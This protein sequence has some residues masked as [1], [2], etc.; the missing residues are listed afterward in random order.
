MVAFVAFVVVEQHI[1]EPSIVTST[2]FVVFIE[3]TIKQPISTTRTITKVFATVEPAVVK[4]KLVVQVV[5]QQV[6]LAKLVTIAYFSFV[7][8]EHTSIV[9]F[10]ESFVAIIVSFSFE[11]LVK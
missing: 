9:T 8:V 1:V 4:P 7:V 5:E 6:E 11:E 2:M 3:A 10:E